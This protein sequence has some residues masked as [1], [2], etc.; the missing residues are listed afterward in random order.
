MNFSTGKN[1]EFIKDYRDL[2]VYYFSNIEELHSQNA[3]VRKYPVTV[4]A[5]RIRYPVHVGD[6]TTS[7]PMEYKRDTRGDSVLVPLDR[8]R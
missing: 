8:R 2:T 7:T 6:R 5:Y 4:Y 1:H 3:F